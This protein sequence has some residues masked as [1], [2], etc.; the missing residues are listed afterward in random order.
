LQADPAGGA[1]VSWV[2]GNLRVKHITAAGGTSPGWPATGL[3][4]SATFSHDYNVRL[5]PFLPSDVNSII[6][7]WYDST[8]PSG[9][10]YR[11]QRF[12][13][14][15]T[16][17]PGWPAGGVLV[18]AVG[19]SFPA[20][21]L[22]SDGQGGA[23]VAWQRGT[24]PFATRVLADGSFA[25]G[26]PAG[27]C[28]LLDAAGVTTSAGQPYRIVAGAGGGLVVA[29]D[30]ARH[31]AV[32]VRVRWFLGD[33]TRDPATP[34][35]G[36]VIAPGDTRTVKLSGIAS[37]G[38]GG[39]FLT[40]T[41]SEPTGGGSYPLIYRSWM[42]RVVYPA[43]VSVPVHGPRPAALALAAA[44]RNPS[45]DAVEVRCTLPRD[46]VA[47]VALYDLNG[48]RLRES[49]V[50][51]AGAHLARF[52]DLGALPPGVYLVRLVQGGES[53]AVRVTLLR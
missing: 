5:G 38:V 19:D 36:L 17:A 28:A 35:T 37:D 4:L 33:G 40:R 2:E 14:A 7:S 47:S 11:L 43:L 12:T 3:A 30:D 21:Q 32:Q 15:G 25:P 22:T 39:L 45:G 50:S 52:G 29:W 16:L 53:R 24:M 18:T 44:G 41:T 46:G 34:D 6:A 8:D 10:A 42:H 20:F 13:P 31:G 9:H 23:Y 49:S 1:Y 51:G 27:G 26:W 48:R